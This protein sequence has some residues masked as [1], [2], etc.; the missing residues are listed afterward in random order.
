VARTDGDGTRDFRGAGQAHPMTG[1]AALCEPHL[2]LRSQ[3]RRSI[4]CPPAGALEAC[5]THGETD[6]KRESGQQPDGEE[7]ARP[8]GVGDLDRAGKW[9]RRSFFVV[10][11]A[12]VRL[13]GFGGE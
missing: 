9:G 10:C 1:G 5:A 13:P 3:G 6:E 11:R 4:E 2:R 8:T 12:A 7:E